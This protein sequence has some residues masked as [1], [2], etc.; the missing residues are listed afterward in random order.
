MLNEAAARPGLS[1]TFGA[2]ASTHWLA[3]ATGMAVL[4][5]G[6]NAFDAAVA[7]GFVLQI[8]EPHQNGP[9]G[10]VP[11]L[12]KPAGSD[13]PVVICGQGVAPALATP[14]RFRALGLGMVPGTG[15][16][17]AVV[18][19]AFGAWMTLLRDYGTM[20]LGE[21]LGYAI[22][23]ARNGYP[24]FHRIL[25]TIIPV[26]DRFTRH[27]PS[28][29]EV[30]IPGG[31]LPQ[32]GQR[33]ATPAVAATYER[34]LQTAEAARGGREAQ[35]DAAIAAYYQGFVAE[36]IDRFYSTAELPDAT[37]RRLPGL[38]RGDDLARW[39]APVETPLAIDYHGVR[40]FKAGPWSQG[41]ADL[42]QLAMLRGLALDG[43]DPVGPEFV[44][45]LTECAK[46]ALADRDAYY[47]DPDFAEVPLD[48]LLSP[49]YADQ[50]RA[51][52]GEAAIPDIRPGRLPGHAALLANLL[53]QAGRDT[54][55]AID[56]G[57]PVYQEL[58]REYG[59]TVHLDV[60]DRHGNIVSATPSGGWLQ[61]SPVVPG[62]GFCITTRGQMFW[63]DE[64]L[65]SSLRPGARPRTT[66]SPTLVQRDERHWIGI[67]APG[68]DQQGQWPLFALLRH[69]HCGMP[70]QQ[71][72]EAPN[73][74]A[75]HFPQSFY[76]R[77]IIANTLSIED[78]VPEAT[79]SDL[80]RR[81]HV[82]VRERPWSLGRVCAVR[83]DGDLVH[84]AASPRQVQAY[85][86]CR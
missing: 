74:H 11:I 78:R 66:L 40:V 47:G 75:V 34:I 13:R 59:D 61:G 19:G 67:G 4:E 57:E 16:L 68:G 28:S 46:L 85:A 9:G 2:V 17:P 18:P 69:L 38:L 29:G 55:P 15:L 6:G 42:Q 49:A 58:P 84:A 76:P 64:G 54:P 23:Y 41:P 63:L 45:L 70:L 3:S 48:T 12:L 31:R 82:V 72:I 73:F 35:I 21:V 56:C 43:L 65:A 62:L 81:G 25:S 44:H 52:I 22:G 77:E 39:R 27:W 83:H 79:L 10:E 80:A 8:V 5:K 20:P 50:R 53:G 14:D 30:W 24:L 33:F 36:A 32:P 26:T 7:A 37:G 60:T 86:I 71:A 51:E 1:G